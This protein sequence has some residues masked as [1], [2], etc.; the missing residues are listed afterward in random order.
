VAHCGVA[1]ELWGAVGIASDLKKDPTT[2]GGGAGGKRTGTKTQNKGERNE[3]G[4]R[5]KKE[6]WGGPT[7]A[8]RRGGV[9][10]TDKGD[11]TKK[12]RREN[13]SKHCI[14]G[15]H[16]PGRRRREKKGETAKQV[17]SAR[18]IKR[19]ATALNRTG[20][21]KKEKRNWREADMNGEEELALRDAGP[22][23]PGL[24]E[25]ANE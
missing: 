15:R 6:L 16:G 14:R 20:I 19:G 22:A 8:K 11:K 21:K 2:G 7:M 10:T 24:Y 13:I 4:G 1:K 18:D 25:Q 3:Q 23:T 9:E 12:N 5:G 17:V